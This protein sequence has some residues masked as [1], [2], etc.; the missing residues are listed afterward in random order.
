M[1]DAEDLRLPGRG[2][3]QRTEVDAPENAPADRERRLGKPL[4]G[5]AY[6]PT[7]GDRPGAA[8]AGRLAAVTISSDG[9]GVPNALVGFLASVLHVAQDRMKRPER[10]NGPADGG[11]G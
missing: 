2:H 5:P 6:R 9:N 11:A 8:Q 3:A 1:L 4:A 7:A 10:T